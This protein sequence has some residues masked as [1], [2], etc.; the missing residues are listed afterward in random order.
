MANCDAWVHPNTLYTEALG[1]ELASRCKWTFKHGPKF[2]FDASMPT[3]AGGKAVRL[4]HLSWMSELPDSYLHAT[5]HHNER[6]VGDPTEKDN[7]HMCCL[8]CRPK[9]HQG[10]GPPLPGDIPRYISVRAPSLDA[11]HG[12]T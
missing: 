11:I 1:R 6:V 9:R 4:S 8:D 12:A 10:G 5:K 7:P 3:T 2:S